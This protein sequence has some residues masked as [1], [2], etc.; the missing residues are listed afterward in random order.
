[1]I[2]S[3]VCHLRIRWFYAWKSWY[4]MLFKITTWNS[5]TFP[6]HLP[7]FRISLTIFQI[8]WQFPDLEKIKFPPTF[9]WRVATLARFK[10]NWMKIFSENARKHNIGLTDGWTLCSISFVS[11]DNRPVSQIRA[12]SGG[13]SRTTGTLWQDYSNCYMFGT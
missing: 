12:S 2:R 8:P 13:L 5:L 4:D 11:G 9:P 10:V 7:L 1:M 6:W 3:L